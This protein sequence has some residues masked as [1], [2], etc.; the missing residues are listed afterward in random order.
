M[1][2]FTDAHDLYALVENRTDLLQYPVD[3]QPMDRS[4]GHKDQQHRP[5]RYRR[6]RRKVWCH[7]SEPVN[8]PKLP[9]LTV[10]NREL[11]QAEN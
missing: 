9:R 6:R 1:G 7:D 11:H 3:F 8:D 2:C 10:P 4:S 5:L